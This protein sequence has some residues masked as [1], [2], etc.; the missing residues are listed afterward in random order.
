M[1]L[2]LLH[3]FP[4]FLCEYHFELC[5]VVPPS[6]IQ[7]RNLILSAFPRNMRLPD[8]FTPNLKVR[9]FSPACFYFVSLAFWGFCCRPQ[10]SR[11]GF[12]FDKAS[13][14]QPNLA[15]SMG[16]HWVM[17]RTHFAVNIT[18]LSYCWSSLRP[19]ESGSDRCT[20]VGPYPQSQTLS[21]GEERQPAMADGFFS[22]PFITDDIGSSTTLSTSESPPM[23]LESASLAE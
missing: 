8:P 4:E 3:D 19:S 22:Q 15:S 14:H 10:Q 23:P 11:S 20:S 1:L 7:M 6:C 16:L 12:S 5:N 9:S 21:A 18:E 17:F 13:P 2:V